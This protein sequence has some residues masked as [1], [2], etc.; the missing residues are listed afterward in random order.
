[1]KL[2][3]GF[4]ISPV[5]EF[6]SGF[7]YSTLNA[8]QNYVG[9]PNA[10]RYPSFFSLDSRLSKDIKVNPKYTV[11]IS[12]SDYNLTNHFNPEAVHSNIADPA[13]GFFFGQRGRRFT[14]DFDV[15]F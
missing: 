6:R 7:P 14:A 11:R 1:V 3:D 2:P 12:L 10:Q 8:G 5:M 15:L 9:M 13:N 4:R